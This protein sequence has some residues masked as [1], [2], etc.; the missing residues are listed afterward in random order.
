MQYG[1]DAHVCAYVHTCTCTYIYTHPC[2]FSGHMLTGHR[3]DTG[4]QLDYPQ[5]GQH[6]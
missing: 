6:E 4:N 1:V 3:L 5:P 2:P